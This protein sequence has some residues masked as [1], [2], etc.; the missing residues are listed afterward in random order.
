MNTLASPPTPYE[1]KEIHPGVYE[2]K[3]PAYPMQ[4][5][6]AKYPDGGAVIQQKMQCSRH[7]NNAESS[8]TWVEWHDL[9]VIEIEENDSDGE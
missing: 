2:N 3:E 6:V 7:D 9:P 1:S 8:H 4:L 5:R